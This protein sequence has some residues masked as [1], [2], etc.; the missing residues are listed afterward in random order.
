MPGLFGSGVKERGSSEINGGEGMFIVIGEKKKILWSNLERKKIDRLQLIENN[1]FSSNV[2][3]LL[4]LGAR[5]FCA[6][7]HH[8]VKRNERRE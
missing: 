4:L 8:R 3:G 1:R 5:E 6:V 2:I 7:K